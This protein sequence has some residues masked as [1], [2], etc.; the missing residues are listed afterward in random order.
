MPRLMRLPTE[1]KLMQRKPDMI[2]IRAAIGACVLLFAL[3]L[4]LGEVA[5]LIFA[6]IGS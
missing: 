3:M 1:G 4:A 5:R 6:I 2:E